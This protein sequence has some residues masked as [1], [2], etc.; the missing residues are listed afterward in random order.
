MGAGREP[1]GGS[2]GVEAVYA[3]DP[4]PVRGDKVFF[5]NYPQ[6]AYTP[7]TVPDNL[8]DGGVYADA[9]GTKFVYVETP[10]DSMGNYYKIEP[11]Q[12]RV[13]EVTSGALFL[14]SDIAL[15]AKPYHQSYTDV[16]W[17]TST[18][19]AWLNG[20]DVSDKQGQ[21]VA[22]PYPD[23]FIGNAF[24]EDEADAVSDAAL[25]NPENYDYNTPGGNDTNDKV[26]FL[27]AAD[28]Q[29]TDFFE[30]QDD[31]ESTGSA[32]AQAMEAYIQEGNVYWWLRSPGDDNVYAVSV[33]YDGDAPIEG[34]NVDNSWVAVRPAFF[35]NLASVAFK[36]NGGN[37]FT[38]IL[39]KFIKPVI[40]TAVLP[41]GKAGAAYNRAIEYHLDSY[42]PTGGEF[43][44]T[45]TV[46]GAGI[47][48]DGLTLD[49][50]TGA[51]SGTPTATGVFTFT[52]HAENAGGF[53]EKTYTLE[54]AGIA[55]AI[56]TAK[57]PDGKVGA[58]YGATLA[59]TGTAP[60][61]WTLAAGKLPDGL[62]LAGAGKLSGTPTKAGTFT[63]TVRAENA[64]GFDERTYTLGIAIAPAITTVTLPDGKVDAS[65]SAT[66]AATGTEP[67]AWTLAGGK[68]PDSLSL[69]GAGKLSGTPTKA[70][71]FTFTVR[72]EN[73]YGF[74]ERTYTLEI[75][76]AA[77]NPPAITTVKL[78]D[79][80]VGASYSATLAATGTA[81]IA[82]TLAGGKLPD[83]L[84]LTGAGKLSGKPT[85]AGTFT[86][87]VKA[88]NGTPPDATKKF[89]VKIAAKTVKVKFHANG[90]KIGKA[91][92]KTV[93]LKLN[94]TK[95]KAIRKLPKATRGKYHFK[96]WYTKK[97][98]GKKVTAKT[99]FT[100]GT[101]LYARWKAK[102]KYG[103]VVNAGAVNV[104]NYPFGRVT[105]ILKRGQTFK[106]KAF[107]NNK[108]SGND[109]YKLT[110]KGRQAYVFARYVKVV[111]K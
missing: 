15:D 99:K 7:A 103:K 50:A 13:L 58:A 38:A 17:E 62:S 14:L 12:W 98:G 11:I 55:P 54:I 60:I 110:Y 20:Y 36:D 75:A 77:S 29:N 100:K 40:G 71:T 86:F 8:V 89:T 57:L 105:G 6:S 32:Y 49:S 27:K 68:L 81:P 28:A 102:K 37:S 4:T 10:A 101:T 64:S 22:N 72:A 39:K 47:L 97:K 3:A 41:P 51:I 85:K 33:Y 35:L 46:T 61:A 106:V 111:Y 25:D 56:T 91:K 53:D 82:W 45:W 107:I 65:Y 19:R 88:S 16:T 30:I 26:F 66:L 90:G 95:G 34:L 93:K 87:T 42:V 52:V 73:A 83:G 70:G 59:A 48:P 96:G 78:P 5:G 104:R 76:G 9:D 67:I 23:S 80:K 84:S 63:F 92:T 74:D 24:D 18:V 109:W 43:A 21:N 94:S 69:T 31:R 108:G 44:P 79:G 2:L 1:G